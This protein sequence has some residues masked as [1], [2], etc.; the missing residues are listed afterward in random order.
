MCCRLKSHLKQLFFIFLGFVLCC[1]VL[2]SLRVRF[3]CGSSQSV[4]SAV[5]MDLPSESGSIGRREYKIIL[6]IHCSIFFLV[7]SHY[8][9]LYVKSTCDLVAIYG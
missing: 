5:D 6:N 8:L 7:I 1:V 3:D 9:S 4:A 2:L